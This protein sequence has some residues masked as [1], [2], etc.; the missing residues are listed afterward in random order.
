MEPLVDEPLRLEL[1]R[2]QIGRDAAVR[3]HRA[4]AVDRDERDDRAGPARDEGP[5][6]L[7]AV[8]LQPGGGGAARF[9]VC[10]LAHEA[11]GAAELAHPRRDV[12]RLPARAELGDGIRV[13]PLR[14]WLREPDDHVQEQVADR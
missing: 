10:A 8:A 5:A 3:S 13:R 7:D 9:V 1:V 12:R 6:H 4:F 14:E 11:G 2:P